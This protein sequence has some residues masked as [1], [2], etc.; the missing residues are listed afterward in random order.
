MQIS[1]PIDRSAIFTEVAGLARAVFGDP[2]LEV[3]LATSSDDVAAWDSMNHITLIVEAE[4]RFGIEFQTAEI[5]RIATIGELVRQ[6]QG[7]L[8]AIR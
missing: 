7:K 1:Q 2:C 3:T 8:V 5:E 4:Y 6:I